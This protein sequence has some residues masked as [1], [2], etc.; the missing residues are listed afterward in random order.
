[1][2]KNVRGAGRKKAFPPETI[3]IVKR[4]FERCVC[5]WRR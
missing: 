2:R 3:G 5:R 4:R 1:M